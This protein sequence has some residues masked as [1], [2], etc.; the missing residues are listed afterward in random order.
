MYRLVMAWY[1]SGAGKLIAGYIVVAVFYI[2]TEQVVLWLMQAF[3][4]Q[5]PAGTVGRT[6]MQ[7]LYILGG[8]TPIFIYHA[9]IAY[10]QTV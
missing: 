9:Y 2:L 6:L 4:I 8:F 5:L 1:Q 3:H 7:L 10:H